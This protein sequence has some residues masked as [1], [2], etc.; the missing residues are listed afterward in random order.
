MEPRS[1]IEGTVADA[2]CELVLL[3]QLP[4]RRI[5]VVVDREPEGVGVDDLVGLTRGIHAA[6]EDAGL[7]PGAYCIEVL[8]PGLDRPLVRDKDFVRFAGARVHVKLRDKRL[9]DDRKNFK[10]RLVGLEGD[11]IVVEDPDPKAEGPWRFP[12]AEVREVRLIPD[13]PTPREAP[14][15]KRTRKPRKSRRKRPKEH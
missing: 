14:A 5:E 8:S 1:L 2:G 3:R 6:F 13:V 15:G 4:G 11:E 9:I 10:G 12:R 7:D